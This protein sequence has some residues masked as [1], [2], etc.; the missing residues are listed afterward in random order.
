[1][2]TFNPSTWEGKA[3]ESLWGQGQAKLWNEF[4]DSRVYSDTLTQNKNKTKTD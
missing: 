2:Y 3:D 4:Q 1:M